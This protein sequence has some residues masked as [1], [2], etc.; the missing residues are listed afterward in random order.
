[1]NTLVPFTNA[2]WETRNT[3]AKLDIT[4]TDCVDI[5]IRV[6]DL[7]FYCKNLQTLSINVTCSLDT[8]IGEMEYLDGSY[9]TL[10]DVELKTS[11]TTGQSLRP[12]LQYCPKIR[13][14]CLKQCTPDVVDVVDELHNENLEIFAYNPN[15]KITSLEEKDKEF[16][17]GPPGLRE[18]YSS[19]GGFGAPTDSFLRL[20]R[21]NQKS[22]QIVF[23]N[24]SITQEQED[25]GEPYPNFKPVYEQW[26]FERLQELHYWPDIYNVTPTMYLESIKFCTSTSLK[27]FAA[28]SAPNIPII[29]DTLMKLPPVE[30]I[31]FFYV[32]YDDDNNYERSLALVELLETYAALPPFKQTLHTIWFGYCDFITN[33]VLDT[34][35]QIKTIKIVYFTGTC[36]VPSHESFLLFLQKIGHQL[37]EVMFVN[38][39]HIG[40]DVLNLLC[41][42]EHLETITLDRI[43]EITE[44]GIKRLVDNAKTLR[45][46]TLDDCIVLSDDTISYINKKIKK[47]KIY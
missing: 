3:L 28:V 9:N 12:L 22:L 46:L 36:T 13:R 27:R 2:L 7:L 39:D 8:F 40:D 21:K 38:I 1:M 31:E 20:L 47:V 29:V 41:E 24:M 43:T 25:R 19:N 18:I 10:I 16:Y 42:M 5:K 32:E 23:A 45:D 6:S 4:D 15:F 26:H 44:E 37:I 33:D 35:T 11:H 14:L 30:H 17:D 34:I